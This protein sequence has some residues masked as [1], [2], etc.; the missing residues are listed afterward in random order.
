MLKK[1]IIALAIVAAFVAALVL[2]TSGKDN[3]T[4]QKDSNNSSSKTETK[5]E[6]TIEITNFSFS[7]ETMIIKKG[8]TVTWI[9]N[10]PT[11][12][13]V[14][15]DDESAGRVEDSKLMS[16]GE[17]VQFT[18]DTVGDFPYHCAPHPYMTGSVKVVE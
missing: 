16:K 6:N 1:V 13:N 18:F 14:V 12:H 2:L 15:F 4:A 8:T 7:P 9:N 11:Q 10:D 5:P 3:N 17:M